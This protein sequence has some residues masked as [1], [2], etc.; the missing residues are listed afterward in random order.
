[1]TGTYTVRRPASVTLD[2]GPEPVRTG[3]RLTVRGT[4]SADGRPAANTAVQLWFR[5]DGAA[6]HT[7]QTSVTTN[8]KG[9]YRRAVPAARSGT[10]KAVV[11]GTSTRAEGVA[12]DAVKVTR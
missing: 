2:A 3:A 12:H 11:P 8:A 1:M 6:G 9:V 7:F 4:L 10:W 5:A